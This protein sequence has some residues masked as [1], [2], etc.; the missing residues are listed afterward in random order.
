M[1]G[2]YKAG[3]SLPFRFRGCFAARPAGPGGET[4]AKTEG[5]EA[6]P[7]VSCQSSLRRHKVGGGVYSLSESFVSK[8]A[9]LGDLGKRSLP[10]VLE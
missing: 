9:M 2:G 3:K 5:G 7:L 4:S 8:S 10:V 1:I 6:W